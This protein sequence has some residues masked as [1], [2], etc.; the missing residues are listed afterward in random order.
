MVV[1]AGGFADDVGHHFGG[2]G[3]LEFGGHAAQ[4]DTEHIPV[5]QFR[6]GAVGVGML[7][8]MHSLWYMYDRRY[9]NDRE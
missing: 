2:A 1:G 3:G 8:G 9:K 7:P 4:G 5:M 6:S